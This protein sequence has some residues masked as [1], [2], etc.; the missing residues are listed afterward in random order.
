MVTNGAKH[1]ALSYFN[2]ENQ[3]EVITKNPPSINIHNVTGA[4]DIA[5][6][7]VL[8]GLL[9]EWSK[10]YSIE[11]ATIASCHAIS[12][13]ELLIENFIEEIVENQFRES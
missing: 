4:G 6:G 11:M 7:M 8:H 10:E 13:N 5:I 2:Q 3:I 12:S 1:A 9:N